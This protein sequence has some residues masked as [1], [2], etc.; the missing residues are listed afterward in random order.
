MTEPTVAQFMT[1]EPATADEGL[2]LA[3]AY[4]RMFIDKIRHLVVLRNGHAVGIVSARDIAVAAAVGV[5]E[6]SKLTVGDAM[7]KNPYTVGPTTPISEVALAM[8]ANRWGCA[9][10][11]DGEDV[12]GVFTTTDALRALRQLAT[13]KPAE[14]AAPA[15]HLPP[16]EPDHARP[17]RVR[18]H[19][20]I[21]AGGS[22]LFATMPK[23]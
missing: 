7:S 21:A 2:R 4:Q 8:E 5:D 14:A 16:K 17:F 13:G 20:P 3:D 12:I 23:K 10:V 11:V 19:R 22:Q 1:E 9:L 15:D 18:R 6:R